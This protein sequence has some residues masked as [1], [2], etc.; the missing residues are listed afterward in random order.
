[1]M[2]VFEINLHVTR[3]ELP[4]FGEAPGYYNTSVA[5]MPQAPY[6]AQYPYPQPQP[7]GA[8]VI[9]PGVNGQMPTVSQIPITQHA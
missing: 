4:W 3:T 8:Y 5:G 7:G 1:M 2:L 6:M 9:Q